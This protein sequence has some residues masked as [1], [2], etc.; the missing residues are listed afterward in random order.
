VRILVSGSTGL[1]G[2]ALVPVLGDAGHAVIRLVR[3]RS[4]PPPGGEV[5]RWDPE[6]GALEREALGRLDA[7]VHLA[8]ED[9][10]SGSWTKAKKA[11]I[12]QSRVEGTAL[13]ARTLSTLDPRPRV[14]AC[15]SAVGYYGDRG[16]ETLT[17]E[18]PPGSGFLAS[19]CRDWEAAATP[20]ADAGIRVAHLRF[21]VVLSPAGGALARM[22]GPFRMGMGGALG[23]GRQY[24]SWIALDDAV[25]AI[26]HVLST[27]T[28]RGA[29]N[30]SSPQ[31]V[32]QLEF[33][34]TLGRALS[35]PTVLGVPAFAVRLMFGDMADELLLASQRLE[36]ARLRGSGYRFLHPELEEA[37]RFVLAS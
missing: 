14:L 31:P 13:L 6:A 18:S 24:V 23:S 4:T 29:V 26:A 8:G 7:V 34:R 16:D 37:L 20:A 36:P 25:R 33:A 10:G 21:A 27:E 15:A 11:R 17:E 28:L 22:L 1:I 19:V 3:P 30:V 9:I 5:A 32:T 2:S 35:R 12:R